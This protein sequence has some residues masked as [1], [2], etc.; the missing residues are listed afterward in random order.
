MKAIKNKEKLRKN[1]DGKRQRGN[2]AGRKRMG[3][4]RLP[5]LKG[6]Q[7]GNQEQNGDK[8]LVK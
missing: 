1:Q 8:I 4:K 7:R 5:G 2:V 3:L 6:K